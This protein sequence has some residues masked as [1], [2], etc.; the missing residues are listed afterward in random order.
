MSR[1][2]RLAH[3]LAPRT[4]AKSVLGRRKESTLSGRISSGS[5]VSVRTATPPDETRIPQEDSHTLL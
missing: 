5:P 1:A 4:P 3:K 2:A